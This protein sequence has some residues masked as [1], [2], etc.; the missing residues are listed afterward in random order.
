MESRDI[1]SVI[2]EANRKL[3]EPCEGTIE[4]NFDKPEDQYFFL[5]MCGYFSG[6]T[7]YWSPKMV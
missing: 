4:L 7:S 5:G 3:D 6:G 1:I 2:M